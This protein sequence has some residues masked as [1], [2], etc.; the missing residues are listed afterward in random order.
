MDKLTLT[1]VH[2]KETPNT[3]RYKEV[4]TAGQP[5]RMGTLYLKQWVTGTPRPDQLTVTIEAQ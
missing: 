5:P 4:T 1:F 3:H 2:E